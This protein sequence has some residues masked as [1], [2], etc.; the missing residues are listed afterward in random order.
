MSKLVAMTL[1]ILPGKT[2][3]WKK[4]VN[5]L[6]TRYKKEFNESRKSVGIYQR[7]F[8]QTTPHGDS[9]ILVLEGA[10]PNDAIRTIWARTDEFTKWLVAQVKEIHGVDLSKNDTFLTPPE[11]V[12]ETE[13]LEE[14]ITN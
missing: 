5:E 6:N 7:T 9:V 1:P 4:F 10:N 11:L 12:M 3:Q 13:P 2:E 14:L 8:F